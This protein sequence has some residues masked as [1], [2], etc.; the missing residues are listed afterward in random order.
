MKT[1]I[2]KATKEENE[3][4]NLG[5][6]L[7]YGQKPYPFENIYQTLERNLLNIFIDAYQQ[8]QDDRR[9]EY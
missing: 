8:G 6:D 9:S 7:G 1:K 4:R 5:Y 3:M 2:Q